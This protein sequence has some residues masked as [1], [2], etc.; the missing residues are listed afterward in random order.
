MR[1]NFG[2][3]KLFLELGAFSF[4]LTAC[5]PGPPPPFFPGFLEFLFGWLVVVAF[6]VLGIFLWNRCY[7]SQERSGN[8]SLNA[9]NERLK[10][11]EERLREMEQSHPKKGKP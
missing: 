9:L 4:F 6:F 5:A 8:Y 7:H 1:T 10:A 11:L 3:L 2:S